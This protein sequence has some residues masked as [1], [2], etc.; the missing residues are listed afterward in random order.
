MDIEGAEYE[1]LESFLSTDWARIKNIIL[2]YHEQNGRTRGEIE[3]LLRENGFGVQIFPS[4]FD[5]SMG[6]VWANNKRQ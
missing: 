1:I 4:K 3:K 6:F 5:K 2:E